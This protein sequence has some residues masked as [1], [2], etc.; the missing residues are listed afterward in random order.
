[1]KGSPTNEDMKN[2]STKIN[3]KGIVKV[4]DKIIRLKLQTDEDDN[5]I[6]KSIMKL[7]KYCYKLI[8]KLKWGLIRSLIFWFD[9]KRPLLT[10]PLDK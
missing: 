8:N 6:T 2:K 4:I 7:R 10:F 9:Q 1:M 5:N 3:N